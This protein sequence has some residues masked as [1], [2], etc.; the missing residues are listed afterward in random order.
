MGE[1]ETECYEIR[2]NTYCSVLSN[3]T[4]WVYSPAESI[5]AG[6]GATFQSITG[7]TLNL[8][9]ILALIRTPSIRKE[10]LTPFI[11]SLAA[12]DMIYSTFTLP[13]IAARDF[14]G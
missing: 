11:L 12:T 10:Y 8:L 7:F 9:V 2:N 6:L 3:A 1:N 14:G 13:I 5:F 4:D